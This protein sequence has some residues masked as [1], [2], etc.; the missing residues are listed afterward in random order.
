MIDFAFLFRSCSQNLKPRT[1]SRHALEEAAAVALAAQQR[2][3]AELLRAKELDTMLELLE[4]TRERRALQRAWSTWRAE[5][6]R[7]RAPLQRAMVGCSITG[8]NAA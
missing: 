4:S 5:V 3:Q 1:L 8:R 7:A 2:Q 6:V